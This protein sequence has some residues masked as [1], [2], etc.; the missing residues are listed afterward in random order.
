MPEQAEDGFYEISDGYQLEWFS[1]MVNTG[2]N[3]LSAR[4][5][6][7]IDMQ[8]TRAYAH[9]QR[10]PACAGVVPSTDRGTESRTLS[11]GRPTEN[12]QGL[13]GYLRGNSDSNTRVC[14]LIIDKSCSFTAYHQVGAIAGCS[15]GW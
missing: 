14:N 3:D 9:P 2:R 1:A 7:D 15:Q 6:N 8:G 4:L 5:M 10:T 13:F 12:I 11:K